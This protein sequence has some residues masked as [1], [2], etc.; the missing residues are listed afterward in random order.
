MKKFLAYLLA[1]LLLMTCCALAEEEEEIM[2]PGEG[3]IVFADGSDAAADAAVYAAAEELNTPADSYVPEDV[4]RCII[5]K[6][7]RI[8]ISDTRQYPFSAIAFMEMKMKCG[9]RWTGTGFMVDKD[10][11]MTAAHCMIC[12]KHNKWA[13]G[14][15]FHFGY[16]KGK[17][18]F[19]TYNG[20]WEAWCGTDFAN[21]YT[22]VNDWAV[23]KFSKK[24]G[25]KT[26]WFGRRVLSDKELKNGY[27]SVAGYKDGILKYDFGKLR[28]IDN[29]RMWVDMDVLPGNS[30]SPIYDSDYYAV[31]IWTTYYD[32]IVANSGMRITPYI[33]KFV[34]NYN[35]N[36]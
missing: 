28:V 1:C 19:Y 34:T 30:G 26:G 22:D 7:N 15:T 10:K 21:G 3:T 32:D 9:C 11:L 8:T 24:V 2:E 31:G 4:E 25:D 35:G 20:H 13:S 33:T 14:I 29:S 5:G 12:Q 23:V 16:R 17:R 27:Y 6:D 36:K 18:D